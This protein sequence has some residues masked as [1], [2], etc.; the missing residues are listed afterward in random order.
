M[1]GTPG[2]PDLPAPRGDRPLAP[3]A[4]PAPAETDPAPEFGTRVAQVQC[5][6]PPGGPAAPEAAP[7]TL[8]DALPAP[9]AVSDTLG[10]VVADVT[11]SFGH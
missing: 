7:A 10:K 3:D 5:C 1:P 6:D 4:A 8:L 9:A 2:S 11:G